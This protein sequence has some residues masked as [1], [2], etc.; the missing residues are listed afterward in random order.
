LNASQGRLALQ[1]FEIFSGKHGDASRG[2]QRS[3]HRVGHSLAKLRIALRDAALGG[4]GQ[5]Q[6]LGHARRGG[7]LLGASRGFAPEGADRDRRDGCIAVDEKTGQ[8]TL[9]DLGFGVGERSECNGADGAK[10][11]TT[12]VTTFR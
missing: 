3:R 2:G 11:E 7:G 1:V 5:G 6:Q 8:V 9:L 10:K 12:H 4:R